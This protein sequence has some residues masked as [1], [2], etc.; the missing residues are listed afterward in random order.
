MFVLQK[1]CLFTRKYINLC[2]R[3]RKQMKVALI[4][5]FIAKVMYK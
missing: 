3:T 5:A 2:I 1:F 4:S